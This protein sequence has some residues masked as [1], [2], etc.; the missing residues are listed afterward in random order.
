MVAIRRA[1]SISDGCN[2]HAKLLFFIGV[3]PSAPHPP[4]ERGA[5]QWPGP[6]SHTPEAFR[7]MGQFFTTPEGSSSPIWDA[8]VSAIPLVR[9]GTGRPIVVLVTDG[10]ANANLL[11]VEESAEQLVSSGVTVSIVHDGPVGPLRQMDKMTAVLHPDRALRWLAEATGGHYF[12]G[13]EKHEPDDTGV[14]ER[15]V[16]LAL[17]IQ[18]QQYAIRFTPPVGT[19][20]AAIRVSVKRAGVVVRAPA[21][22]TAQ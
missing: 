14:T 15:R 18:R 8:V 11:S 16:A 5:P 13:S 22:I 3:S 7:S 12:R 9:Q 17:Q 21:F 1:S 19:G 2:R 6:L 20:R 10:K 4:P